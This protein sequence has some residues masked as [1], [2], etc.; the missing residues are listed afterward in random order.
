MC[1]ARSA[2]AL[3]YRTRV[4]ASTRHTASA[5][6]ESARATSCAFTECACGVPDATDSGGFSPGFERA[7]D[8]VVFY[9]LTARCPAAACYSGKFTGKPVFVSDLQPNRCRQDDKL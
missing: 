4:A 2:A 6:S 7:S 1:A 8:M 3:R 9:L 5:C